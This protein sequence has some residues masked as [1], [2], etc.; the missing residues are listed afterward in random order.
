MQ[1]KH[2]RES[3]QTFFERLYEQGGARVNKVIEELFKNPKVTDH[4]GKTVGR[5][6]GAKRQIDRNMQLLLS[7]LNLPSR[8]DYN[9]LLAKIETLQGSLVNLNMKLD[10]IM[11]AQERPKPK[12]ALRL[13][14]KQPSTTHAHHAAAEHKS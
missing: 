14:T 6:A 1:S 7:L 9:R 2:G 8:A 5:A 11:A 10:R 12:R 13:R 4:L 3:A